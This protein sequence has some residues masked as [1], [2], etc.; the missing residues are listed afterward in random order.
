MNSNEKMFIVRV[1]IFKVPI[2]KFLRIW[3]HSVKNSLALIGR[4]L[5]SM[6]L[7]TMEMMVIQFVL[8]FFALAI[9]RKT[10][11]EMD[12]KTVNVKKQIDNNLPWSVLLSTIEMTSQCSKLRSET[13]RLRLVVSCGSENLVLNIFADVISMVD[14]STDHGKLLSIC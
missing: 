14:K 11:T 13:T 5:C 1:H 3:W 6:G 12:F 2:L 9:F 8:L 10:S 7:Q 4:E